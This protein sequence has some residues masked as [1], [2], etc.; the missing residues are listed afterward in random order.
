MGDKELT[1]QVL[2]GDLSEAKLMILV[3]HLW[4]W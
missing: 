2:K 4:V 3:V 1:A